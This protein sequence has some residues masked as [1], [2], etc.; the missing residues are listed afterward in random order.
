MGVNKRSHT[1]RIR[2][3]N[4][5]EANHVLEEIAQLTRILHVIEM[6]MQRSIEGIKRSTEAF[7]A[8]RR[9][10]LTRLIEALTAYATQHKQTLFAR[11]RGIEL[12]CGTMGFRRSNAMRPQGGGSWAGVLERIKAL[13]A[14]E[15]IRIREEVDRV[16]LRGWSRERLEQLGVKKEEKDLFWYAVKQDHMNPEIMLKINH[17][18]SMQQGEVV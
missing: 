17:S 14:S 12:S 1:I 13:G 6:D 9:T 10:R 18:E 16:A 7:A 15:G 8:P 2:V 3:R 4:L 5:Q 11:K